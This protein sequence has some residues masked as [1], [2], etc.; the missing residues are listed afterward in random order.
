MVCDFQCTKF[1]HLV[2]AS[3]ALFLRKHPFSAV[4]SCQFT[5]DLVLAVSNPA[6]GRNIPF[7]TEMISGTDVEQ[8]S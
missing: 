8:K 1:S 5:N 7:F 4:L 2:T 6:E 3:F